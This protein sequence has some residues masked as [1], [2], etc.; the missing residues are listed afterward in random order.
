MYGHTFCT[1]T[2]AHTGTYKVSVAKSAVSTVSLRQHVCR[3]FVN[4]GVLRLFDMVNLPFAFMSFVG[5]FFSFH[6]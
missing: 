6:Y 2:H 1:H 4:R 3:H 5:D